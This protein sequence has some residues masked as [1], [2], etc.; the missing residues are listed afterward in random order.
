MRSCTRIEPVGFGQSTDLLD[1]LEQFRTSLLR[2]N[3]P[4]KLSQPAYIRPERRMGIEAF[5]NHGRNLPR[6]NPPNKLG[7]REACGVVDRG[8]LAPTEMTELECAALPVAAL[9]L[10]IR[11]AWS[12]K[13]HTA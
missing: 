13:E 3:L 4:K 10:I 2:Q 1:R 6:C 11:L 9:L 7:N 12:W 5:L 8:W